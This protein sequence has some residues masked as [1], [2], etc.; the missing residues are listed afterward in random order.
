MINVWMSWSMRLAPQLWLRANGPEM[1]SG[2]ASPL[3]RNRALSVEDLGGLLLGDDSLECRRPRG[4]DEVAGDDTALWIAVRVE[5]ERPDDRAES[6]RAHDG[7][8]DQP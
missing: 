7:L 5:A 3:A 8:E 2:R 4:A 1:S 6:G